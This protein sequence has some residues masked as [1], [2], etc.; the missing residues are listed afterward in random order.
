MLLLKDARVISSNGRRVLLEL[1]GA[2]AQLLKLLNVLLARASRI[3]PLFD[4]ASA[5]HMLL[6]GGGG[7]LVLFALFNAFEESKSCRYH[8]QTRCTVA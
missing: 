2:G 6:I 1:R 8:R 5:T 4:D 3:A 7:I